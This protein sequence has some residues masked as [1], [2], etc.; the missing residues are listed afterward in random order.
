M[1]HINF[2]G[3]PEEQ[4]N[5]QGKWSSVQLSKHTDGTSFASFPLLTAVESKALLGEANSAAEEANTAFRNFAID[6]QGMLLEH[7]RR[8]PRTEAWVKEL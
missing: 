5:A 3:S 8:S 7:R 6:M 4:T 2:S 1:I